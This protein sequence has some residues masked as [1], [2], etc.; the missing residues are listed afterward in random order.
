MILFFLKAYWKQALLAI[1][2]SVGCFLAYSHIYHSGYDAASAVYEAKIKTY[3][4]KLDKR[5][6][7]IEDTSKIL[8]SASASQAE[9]RTQELDAITALAKKKVLFTVKGDKCTPSQDFLNSYN[10]LISRGNQK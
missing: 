8:V 1:L 9:T 3:N 2:I 5:I 10:A 4:D 6:S 7:G